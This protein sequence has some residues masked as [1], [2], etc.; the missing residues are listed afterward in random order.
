[1]IRAANGD[2]LLFFQII[3][4][5]MFLISLTYKKDLQELDAHLPAHSAF[6]DKYY[7]AGKLIVSGRKVPRTGGIILAHQLTRTELE[8]ILTEDPFYTNG[9]ADYEITEFTPTKH[10]PEFKVFTD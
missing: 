6:L 5:Q 9:L 7:Q 1:M 3:S 10:A 4:E 2:F 8:Q